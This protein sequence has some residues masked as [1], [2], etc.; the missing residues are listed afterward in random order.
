MEKTNELLHFCKIRSCNNFDKQLVI[1]KCYDKE[2]K[3]IVYTRNL[4]FLESFK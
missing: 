1:K 4:F 3:F 2:E